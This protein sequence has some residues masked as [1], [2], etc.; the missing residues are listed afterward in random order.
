VAVHRTG[1]VQQAE[2]TPRVN[3]RAGVWAQPLI[4]LQ[5]PRALISGENLFVVSHISTA[6]TQELEPPAKLERFITRN[7]KGLR[8]H[9]GSRLMQS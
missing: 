1:S 5:Y 3:E 2:S 4:F 6:Y 9:L 7:L 8:P